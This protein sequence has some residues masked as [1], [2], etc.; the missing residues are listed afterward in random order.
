MTGRHARVD[1]VGLV[2]NF[3]NVAALANVDLE[4]ESGITVLLG[5]NGAGKTTLVRSLVGIERPT[6]GTIHVHVDGS[7]VSQGAAQRFMGWMPQAFGFPKFMRVQEFVAYAGWLKGLDR[8]EAARLAATALEITNL[9]ESSGV[10]LDKL[11]G[12]TLR[13]AGLAAAIVHQPAI[14]IL[15]E[16]TAGLDPIQRADLHVRLRE[17]SGASAVLV[18][19]HLLEDVQE[20]AENICVLDLGRV[21]WSGTPSQLRSLA[22]RP[23][24]ALEELRGGLMSLIG[25]DL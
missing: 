21:K 18:A 25:T 8:A 10:R 12:G 7:V 17:F 13:R 14:L 4:F 9:E 20:L 2:K 6:S 23:G 15:D 16:P 1:V 5:R 19:T 11:S 24:T 22:P 3:G